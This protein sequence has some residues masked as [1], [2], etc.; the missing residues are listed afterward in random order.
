VLQIQPDEGI[1]IRFNAKRPGREMALESVTMDFKYSDWFNQAPAVGYET[2]LYDVFLG[3]GTLFQRADQVEASWKVVD[4]ILKSWAAQK[5]TS[6][7]NYTS[8]SAGPQAAEELL[9]RDG[10]KWREIR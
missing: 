8:G 4:P 1:K 9:A 2:L 6:F 5:P 7:P 10:R 3:D